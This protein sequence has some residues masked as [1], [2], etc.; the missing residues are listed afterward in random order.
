MRQGRRRSEVAAG[1]GRLPVSG[2]AIKRAAK[3]VRRRCCME[4]SLTPTSPPA[5]RLHQLE[6]GTTTEAALAFF[7]SLPAVEVATMI[8]SWRGNWAETPP[9]PDWLPP[10]GGRP[11]DAL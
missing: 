1:G 10:R 2:P 6:S 3:H 7:D 5:Q 9:P 4:A 11:A 8:G